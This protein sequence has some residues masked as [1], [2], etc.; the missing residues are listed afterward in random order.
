MYL[1][2]FIY[3]SDGKKENNMKIFKKVKKGNKRKFYFCGIKIFTYKKYKKLSEFERLHAKRFDENLSINDKNDIVLAHFL[4]SW[5][6]SF[7]IYSPKT[8][9]EKI[10]WLK[11]FYKDPLMPLYADKYLVRDFIKEKI[12]EEYLVPLLGAWDNPEEIDFDKLP[13]QFALK[14]NW[15]SG[16][17]IIVSDKSKLDINDAK[18]KLAKWLEPHSNHYYHSL[19]WAYKNIKPKI[20]CEK[21]IE[22]MDNNLLDYK[23][24]CFN[25]NPYCIWVDFDRFTNHKRNFYDLDWNKL[26]I[27]L[28][29]ESSDDV[30]EKPKNLE[31]MIEF[32]KIFAKEFPFLR[33]DFY[34]VGGQLYFGELTFYPGNGMEKFALHKWD[35]EFGDLIKLPNIKL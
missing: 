5:G 26:N 3:V 1:F 10:Q 34:E 9:N 29:H 19:E 35:E 16:Q 17:N 12:G 28:R 25:G 8:F 15:G 24:L 13:N 30:I 2:E 33:V 6:Y 14:V 23:V 21:Y 32:S 11:L 4:N 22:Q 18:E 20:I 27:K 31:K 7:D